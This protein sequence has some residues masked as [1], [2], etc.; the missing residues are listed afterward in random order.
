MP[1]QGNTNNNLNNVIVSIDDS[2]QQEGNV[3]SQNICTISHKNIKNGMFYSTTAFLLGGLFT[4]SSIPTL[5]LSLFLG[6]CISASIGIIMIACDQKN[7][8]LPQERRSSLP[9]YEQAITMTPS[10]E[11]VITQ[12]SNESRS[13]PL[14]SQ[15]KHLSMNN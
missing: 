7:L 10:Y 11:Q 6:S 5:G 1:L 15:N 14:N 4:S 2:V 13:S 9:S 12:E 8:I 3:I